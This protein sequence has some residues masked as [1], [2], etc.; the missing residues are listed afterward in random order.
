[1][2]IVIM[3][4]TSAEI[5]LQ[6]ASIDITVIIIVLKKSKNIWKNILISLKEYFLIVWMRIF[7][8]YVF[9]VLRS[10]Q[11]RCRNEILIGGRGALVVWMRIFVFYVFS[12]LRS[13]Q[14]RCRN[15]ILI[16]GRGHLYGKEWLSVC[17]RKF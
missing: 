1:M 3:L 14:H 2:S 8:F 5:I 16:G 12:V 6:L 10:V 4:F 9:S 7:V 17:R 15:E 11:H 13:V